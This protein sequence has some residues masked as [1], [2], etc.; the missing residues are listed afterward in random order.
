MANTETRENPLE[1]K[2]REQKEKAER[3]RLEKEKQKGEAA[4]SSNSSKEPSW[5]KKKPAKQPIH[6]FFDPD[7]LKVIKEQQAKEGTGWKSNYV[8]DKIRKAFEEEGWLLPI[9]ED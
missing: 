9:D 7:V 1:K 4:S 6:I 3:E 5:K 8:N 2:A